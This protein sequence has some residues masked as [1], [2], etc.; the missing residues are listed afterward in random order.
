MIQCFFFV[1]SNFCFLFSNV[2]CLRG[3]PLSNDSFPL[4]YISVRFYNLLYYGSMSVLIVQCSFSVVPYRFLH[5]PMSFFHFPI[6]VFLVLCFFSIV[7]C[8]FSMVIGTIVKCLF[9]LSDV[10]FPL[11]YVGFP[12]SKIGFSL[13]DVSFPLSSAYQKIRKRSACDCVENVLQEMTGASKTH[14]V[15]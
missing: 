1:L 3:F 6:L 15:A 14:T 2:G 9:F 10:C 5:C 7:Q 11:S 12:W 13:S 8:Q 4:S